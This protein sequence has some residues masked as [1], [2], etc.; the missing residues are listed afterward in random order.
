MALVLPQL[1]WS[2]KA[3]PSSE[4]KLLVHNE[5][6]QRP[7]FGSYHMIDHGPVLYLSPKA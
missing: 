7:T 6:F 1:S 3:D 5:C 2:G 4:F